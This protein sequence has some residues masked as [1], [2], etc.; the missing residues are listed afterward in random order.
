MAISASS[1][2][3]SATLNEW[4]T[5]FNNLVTDVT[6]IEGGSISYTT[7]N[8][9]TTNA[10]TLNVKEDGTI[11]FEGATDDGFETTLTVVDPTAD[12]TITFPNETGTVHTTGGTTTHTGILV[13]DGGNIGSASDSDALAISSGGVVT[14]SQR[15]IHSAGITIADGGQIGS[16]SDTDA[17]DIAA[18]GNVTLTQN[19]SVGGDLDVTGTLDLSDS[20]FTNVGSIQLDSIA[21]D[22]DTDSSITFSGSDVITIATGGSTA[23]TFNA[24]QVTTLSGNLI[25]P[26]AGNI[27]S[28]S[29][30]DAIA[31]G[32]DGDITLTQDLELQHDGAI[33]SFGANDE[34][35]LTHV[36]NTGLLLTDSGGT[37]TLQFHDANESFASDGSKIIMVSGGTTFNMPTSDGTDGQ[38]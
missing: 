12:R 23:A 11:V 13:A 9:T 21:G 37:P 31:I 36:H 1:I 8:T 14:F 6:A 25:I 38:A 32:S 33:L 3:R 15:D 18:N 20:N 27:G 4:R 2:A 28:A 29:D 16:A 34:I 22:G 17:I 30:T 24:S 19:L 5:Q 26:D 7:L 10:T 35:A